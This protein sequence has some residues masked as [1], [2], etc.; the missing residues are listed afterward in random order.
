MK[1]LRYDGIDLLVVTAGIDID[2]DD[3]PDAET[4]SAIASGDA[5]G[6]LYYSVQDTNMPTSFLADV[7]SSA[8]S[9]PAELRAA[10]G[11]RYD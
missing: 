1:K 8:A 10:L 2:P 7:G 4:L 3:C 9:T 11:G 5:K 6:A